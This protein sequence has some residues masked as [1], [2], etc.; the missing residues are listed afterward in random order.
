MM[1]KRDIDFPTHFIMFLLKLFPELLTCSHW[2][3]PPLHTH[4]HTTASSWNSREDQSVTL[5]AGYLGSDV[6][7][8]LFILPKYKNQSW[9]L[10][11]FIFSCFRRKWCHDIHGKHHLIFWELSGPRFQ[12]E[13]GLEVCFFLERNLSPLMTSEFDERVTQSC[14][15]MNRWLW[16][17]IVCAQICVFEMTSI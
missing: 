5:I 15:F 9:S 3:L 2:Y 6:W 4:T 14:D 12:S 13:L 1:E 10:Q 17:G 8:V 11:D 16:K 7:Q